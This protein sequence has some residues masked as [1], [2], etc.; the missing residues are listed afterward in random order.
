MWLISPSLLS[1]TGTNLPRL[2]LPNDVANNNTAVE[3]IPAKHMGISN[4]SN[5]FNEECSD[6]HS[7][8][9]KVAEKNFQL[10][11]TANANIGHEDSS[12]ENITTFSKYDKVTTSHASDDPI[13]F[14]TELR[15]LKGFNNSD[16][17]VNSRVEELEKLNH[18]KTTPKEES[19]FRVINA[20]AESTSEMMH[21]SIAEAVKIKR[22]RI[23]KK[24]VD[25]GEEFHEEEYDCSGVDL[26]NASE[27]ISFTADND[28]VKESSIV[29]ANSTCNNSDDSDGASHSDRI[30]S[31]DVIS[32]VTSKDV[33]LPRSSRKSK[34]K[35]LESQ[36]KELEA[37][38]KRLVIQTPEQTKSKKRRYMRKMRKIA[39]TE[40]KPKAKKVKRRT[41]SCSAKK[42]AKA[43]KSY[44]ETDES[45]N[46]DDCM[47]S[48]LHPNRYELRSSRLRYGYLSWCPYELRPRRRITYI[49]KESR[50]DACSSD[51]NEHTA[52]DVQQG[53]SDSN[54][55]GSQDGGGFSD[56]GKDSFS[57]S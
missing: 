40:I 1:F 12:V 34:A 25:S 11:E 9:C 51:E 56:K 31:F 37:K 21:Q 20:R 19:R 52:D 28:N 36:V 54:E 13:A 5:G 41:R 38:A 27:P 42:R 45:F 22:E 15:S 24:M 17:N 14:L 23:V 26:E 4:S 57:L 6:V 32:S 53:R 16:N 33:A 55:I 46:C 30:R 7:G 18:L 50:N 3:P 47:V 43:Y 10:A 2:V 44:E 29:T 35:G 49:D 48:D 8:I 39:L